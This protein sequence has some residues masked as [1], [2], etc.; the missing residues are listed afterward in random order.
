MAQDIHSIVDAREKEQLLSIPAQRLIEKLSLLK[1][2]KESSRKR[3]F[4][5]LLQNASDYNQTVAVRLTVNNNQVI[6]EH[7]GS[8]FSI[9]D[10]LNMISPDSNKREDEKHADNIGKFGTGLVSTHILSSVMEVKGV[11]LEEGES[12]RFKVKLDRSPYLVK[13][14]LV[15]A[16]NVAKDDFKTSLT[17]TPLADGFQTSITYQL[18]TALPNLPVIKAEE[19]DLEYLYEVLPYTLCFMPKV[20]E[21]TIRDERNG[22][23]VFT[24]TRRQGKPEDVTF[25]IE[26]DGQTE[27]QTFAYFEYKGVSSVYRYAEG[28]VLPFPTGISRIFCGLPLIGTEGIGLPFLLNSFKF[29]P[30]TEREGI[31]LEPGSNDQNRSLLTESAVLYKMILDRVQSEKLTGAYTLTALTRKYNGTQASNTQFVNQFLP[32]YKAEILTHSIVRNEKGVFIPFSQVRLP[33]LDSKADTALYDQSRFVASASLPKS[34]DYKQWFEATDFSLFPDQKY[35][36]ETLVKVIEQAGSLYSFGHEVEEV[37]Q[38]LPDCLGFI[39]QRNRY[40]F[41]QH[42]I[43]PNQKGKFCLSTLKADTGLPSELKGI[44]ND[45]FAAEGQKIEDELLDRD[46]NDLDVLTLECRL[47]DLCRRIDTELANQYAKNQGD[48]SKINGPLNR[49]Y[50]WI[51]KSEESKENLSSWFHWYYPKRATLIVDMLS[52]SQREQAL[53]IAQSGKMEALAQLAASDLTDNEIAML[54]ANIGR[55]SALL[56]HLNDTVDDKLHA[57][58]TRGD[59]GEQIVYDDLRR[60]YPAS[61]GFKVVWAAKEGKPC[62]DFRVMKGSDVVCYCDA[63]TTS[64]GIANADSIPFFMRKSQWQF[65][66]TL[67]DS[68]PYFI[69]RVFMGDGGQIKYMRIAKREECL[70]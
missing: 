21:V 44:Y 27:T 49:L 70:C 37:N 5:E 29:E 64:R 42:A 48:T 58:G 66:Q 24:I 68:I 40:V 28:A 7:D 6:F 60:K 57:D 3:W 63:K 8:P 53:T 20:R 1:N 22:V 65:L 46:Y 67:D 10:V 2:R 35:T 31:E 25:C 39:K 41:S 30:T 4:W 47:E 50:T 9:T 15:E 11:C 17:P 61:R 32:K 13:E 59:Q 18:G 16:I 52:D 69:A 51:S 38:W 36:Y 55:L 54:T 62:Y 34:C 43:L 12:Y 26:H 14:K 56:A 33:F 45:L 23:S 19:V